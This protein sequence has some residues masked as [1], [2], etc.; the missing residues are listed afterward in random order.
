M[1]QCKVCMLNQ[2]FLQIS[3][4][5]HTLYLSA[6][7]VHFQHSTH[8]TPGKLTLT[9]K[10]SEYQSISLSSVLLSPSPFNPFV[11]SL[12]NISQL[13]FQGEKHAANIEINSPNPSLLFSF[14]FSFLSLPLSIT[15]PAGEAVLLL[16]LPRPQHCH[17]TTTPSGQEGILA[18]HTPH[19][20]ES[21]WRTL[22]QQQAISKHVQL[23]KST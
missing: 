4:Q 14:L 9:P 2:G 19:S 10:A 16:H 23:S 11:S 5:K 20:R 22:W 15:A 1:R 12:Q 21:E 8:E 13:S 17:V 7:K 18:C 6:S 3:C